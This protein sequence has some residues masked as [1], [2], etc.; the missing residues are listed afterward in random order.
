MSTPVKDSAVATTRLLSWCFAA[1]GAAALV[2]A[3]AIAQPG[4]PWLTYL[5]FTLGAAGVGVALT[6][7]LVHWR[8]WTSL[9]LGVAGAAGLAVAGLY[10]DAPQVAVPLL[11]AVGLTGIGLLTLR[12]AAERRTEEQITQRHTEIL[13]A[14]KELRTEIQAANRAEPRSA[15]A[16]QDPG[17]SQDAPRASREPAAVAPLGERP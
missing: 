16:G 9:V 5:G 4:Y 8:G 11:A 3:V 6:S 13:D 7:R 12:R 1:T 2:R 14:I 15:V 10:G 17:S